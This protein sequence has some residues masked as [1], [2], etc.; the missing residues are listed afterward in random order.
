[1]G[2]IPYFRSTQAIGAHRQGCTKSGFH[3]AGGMARASK[4][5][6]SVR[7]VISRFGDCA[8]RACQEHPL[9]PNSIATKFNRFGRVFGFGLPIKVCD[10]GRLPDFAFG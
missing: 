1:M 6:S 7:I 8:G 5:A 9:M 3:S 4:P 2:A 10:G